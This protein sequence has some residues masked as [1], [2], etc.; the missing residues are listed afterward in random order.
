MLFSLELHRAEC[1][2]VT[3]DVVE[4]EQRL[5]ELT[6]RIASATDL[7]VV[8]RRL[9]DLYTALSKPDRAV[10]AGLGCRERLGIRWL[11]HPSDDHVRQEY[12]RVRS[13]LETERSKE[14]WICR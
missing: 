5:Q 3:G 13:R 6:T 10:D 8:A 11:A 14:C 2:F 9:V 7:A 4:A 1:E 12:E